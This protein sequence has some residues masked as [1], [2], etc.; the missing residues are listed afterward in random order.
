[1]GLNSAEFGENEKGLSKADLDLTFEE[2]VVGGG[3]L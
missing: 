2:W 3:G 1:M